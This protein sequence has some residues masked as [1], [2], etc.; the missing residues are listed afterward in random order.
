MKWIFTLLLVFTTSSC[1]AL[2]PQAIQTAYHNSYTYENL[3]DYNNAIKALAPVSSAHPDGYTVNLRLGWLNF[4]DGQFAN[5]DHYYE[6]AIK[7]A[8][9]AL[10]P[11]LGYLMPL[12]AQKKYAKAE[13]IEN[14]VLSVDPYNYYGNL[15]LAYTLRMEKKYDAAEKIA[16]KMLAIYPT[17]VAFMTELAQTKAARGDKAKASELF[18][19]ILTLDPGNTAANAYLGKK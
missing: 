9:D 7:A 11:K 12:L 5:A 17:N 15:R 3:R 8:P 2:S 1:F 19:H 14:Q 10:E 6:Q 4:L 18:W 16:N 13:T